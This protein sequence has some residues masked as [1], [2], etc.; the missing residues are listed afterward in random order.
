MPAAYRAMGVPVERGIVVGV[1]VN[2]PW[3]DDHPRGIKDFCA[4]VGVNLADFGNLAILNTKVSMVGRHQSSIDD[5][6]TFNDCIKLWH[7]SLL[8]FSSAE[9]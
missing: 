3:S 1:Q 7:I 8:T 2:C 6:S 5:R 9:D 4:I